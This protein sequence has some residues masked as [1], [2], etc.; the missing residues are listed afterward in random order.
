MKGTANHMA[1]FH[2]PVH[3]RDLSDPPSN[4]RVMLSHPHSDGFR[5]AAEVKY[6]ALKARGTWEIIDKTRYEVIQLVPLKWI[7]IYKFDENGFF[8]KYKARLVMKKDLQKMNIQDVYAVTLTFKIFRF[9]MIFVA[10]FDLKI[11][12]LNAINAFLN[13]KNDESIYC[14]LSD[15][16]RKPEKIMKM[17]RILY[18]QQKSS[19]L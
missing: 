7:F 4:W 9:F 13:A 8:N 16:Y 6:L 17:L 10:A 14:F 2:K 5:H 18:D 1:P 19:L 11:R 15:D 3:L 12:Q